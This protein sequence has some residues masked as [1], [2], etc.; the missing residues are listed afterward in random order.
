MG[1]VEAELLEDRGA[2]LADVAAVGTKGWGQVQASA[3]AQAVRGEVRIELGADGDGRR[4][5]CRDGSDAGDLEMGGRRGGDGGGQRGHCRVRVV[6]EYYCMQRRGK[7]RRTGD[8]P[9]TDRRRWAGEMLGAR[10]ARTR[11]PERRGKERKKE[12]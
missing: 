4:R 3:L 1:V 2:V 10:P 6:K 11:G 7:G 8:G 12:N 9:T 5:G